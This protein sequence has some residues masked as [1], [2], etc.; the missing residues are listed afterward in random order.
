[1]SEFRALLASKSELKE[2]QEILPFFRARRQ[3]A[4]TLGSVPLGGFVPD[5]MAF[6]F[7]LFGDYVCDLVV[8]D[9][10]LI[11]AAV[12]DSSSAGELAQL[13]DGWMS[14]M[15]GWTNPR[16]QAAARC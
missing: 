10:S 8:G 2:A 16:A 15:S 12:R 6:E 7:E 5:R 3:L 1:L 13:I 9:S 14:T 4:T 11:I